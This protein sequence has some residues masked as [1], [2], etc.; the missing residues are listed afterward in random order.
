MHHLIFEGAE[1]SGKSWIM[2]QVY[3][4]LEPKYNE[5]GVILDGCHWFNCDVGVFGTEY[6]Q[7]VIAE[8]VKIFEAL[9]K[10]NILAEKF[11]LS[12]IVYNR[13]HFNREV[14]YHAVEDELSELEFK[15]ILLTFPEDKKLIEKRIQ[16]RLNIY[17]HYKRIMHE[18]LWYIEQQREYVKEAEKSC[19]PV[20]VVEMDGL[21]DERPVADILRWVEEK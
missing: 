10:K 2:S 4:K 19:L 20:L 5:S 16:D 6:G 12:D 11:H 8:Y 9:K 3:D 17:P 7:P 14:E 1:L 21:P 18:A 13:M 15:I